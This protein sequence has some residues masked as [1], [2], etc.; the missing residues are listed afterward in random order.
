MLKEGPNRACSLHLPFQ[1]MHKPFKVTWSCLTASLDKMGYNRKV[2]NTSSI[3]IP[4]SNG[5]ER[6]SWI[7]FK[8]S[9]CSLISSIVLS[10]SSIFLSWWITK[11]LVKM[12]HSWEVSVPYENK[13]HRVFPI[14]FT[15]SKH[16]KLASMGTLPYTQCHTLRIS[17]TILSDIIIILSLPV[18]WD[19]LICR[20][21]AP[22]WKDRQTIGLRGLLK[23]FHSPCTSSKCSDCFGCG[24]CTFQHY[25]LHTIQGN[26]WT[27]STTLKVI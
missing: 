13:K 20:S 17:C 26:Q 4:M 8:L 3:S 6:A 7:C 25:H 5:V 23:G 16:V 10:T 12:D 11:N 19:C 18:L 9:V 24:I 1:A 22:C 14:L 21:V 2:P 15:G 27:V